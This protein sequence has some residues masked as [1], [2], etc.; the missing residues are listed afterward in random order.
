MNVEYLMQLVNVLKASCTLTLVVH[1]IDCGQQ[2][3]CSINHYC[4]V[5]CCKLVLKLVYLQAIVVKTP[6][7]TVSISLN[8]PGLL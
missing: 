7:I 2:S 5:T 6:L 4:A 8:K 3:C 1:T